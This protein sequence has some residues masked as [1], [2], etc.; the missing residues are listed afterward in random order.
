MRCWRCFELSFA[1]SSNCAGCG[2][3]L[4]LEGDLGA[5]LDGCPGCGKYEKLHRI[6]V[7]EHQLLECMRCGGVLV[8]R[9]T[10][11]QLT[12]AREVE[13]G[14]RAFEAATVTKATLTDTAV[15]YRPCGTCE[16]LMMRRN[17][18]GNS[19]VI[20]DVCKDNGIWFDADELAAVLRFVASG[21]L[22]RQRES[23]VADA[24]RELSQRRVEAL[25]E[26]A[27]MRYS[28]HGSSHDPFVVESAAALLSAIVE[29]FWR[30]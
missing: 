17:F 21:G 30:R 16:Q 2:A 3:R 24:K 8:D 4:G 13:S 15:R 6:D 23:A 25:A 22:R 18:G 29:V 27:K 20:V 7:G 14:L 5:T 9:A 26:Q 12:R 11:E 19:G 1:G 10:L 28:A